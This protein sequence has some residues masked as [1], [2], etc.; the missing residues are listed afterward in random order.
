MGCFHVNLNSVHR[1]SRV[2]LIFGFFLK[3]EFFVFFI[4][5]SH[6]MGIVKLYLL[7]YLYYYTTFNGGC[8][9]VAFTFKIL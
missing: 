3:N 6:S 1:I 4:M 8:V 2:F 7:L 9:G 5:A